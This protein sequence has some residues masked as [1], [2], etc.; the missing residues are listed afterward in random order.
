MTVAARWGGPPDLR[1]TLAKLIAQ[2]PPGRVT[3]CGALA[4]ALGNPI[5]ARW[6]G[7]YLLHHP[8]GPDCACHRVVRAGGRLG[9]YIGGSTE[10][11]RRRLVAEGVEVVAEQVDLAVWEYRR[12][13]SDRPLERL[14]AQQEEIARRVKIYP[15]RRVG[16]LVAGVDVAYGTADQ[17]QG[18]Y[19]LCEVATGRLVWA[20]T[21]RMPVV[22]P[23]ITSYL[24]FRE[25]PVLLA[26]VEA[27]RR[28]GR[29]SEVVL[30]DGT[31]V[32]HPRRAGIAAHLGVEA[33]VATVGVTKKWLC[34]SVDSRP[35][36]SGESRP[37]LLAGRPLGVA[38]RPTCGSA[39]PL[40]V[41]PG[42]RTDLAFA[43]RL[44][45]CLL[46]GRRLPAP[47]YWADRL[48]RS[49]LRAAGPATLEIMADPT[50]PRAPGFP[51][52]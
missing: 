10:A 5:A 40:Y 2:I 52:V 49:G 15:R 18:V 50:K 16:R 36:A 12:L 24:T 9:P 33:S 22:F 26:L 17:A 41:S 23:Y 20:A 25:L 7:H 43:E 42:H 29:L 4:E 1:Q 51:I 13:R 48:S 14:R 38:L 6:I 37:V 47:L 3:T 21:V 31:G 27:A 11:K 19:A 45:R 35:M 44:V 32:L 46:H 39:R 34:G 28:A 8:H 30:V